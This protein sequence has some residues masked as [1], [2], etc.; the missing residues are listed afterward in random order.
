MLASVG[1]HLTNAEIA[2]RLFIS[3]RT[4]ESHVSSLLRKFGVADRRAL[5]GIAAA[6]G[7]AA[8]SDR[9]PGPAASRRSVGSL[10]NPL[11]PFVGRAVE[12]SALAA[13]LSQARLVTAVGPG[14]IGKTRLAVAVAGEVAERFADGVR[15]VDLVPVQPGDRGG[16]VADGLADEL[17]ELGLIDRCRPDSRHV[18]SPP[19]V[20]GDPRPRR[21]SAVRH[22]RHVRGD[23]GCAGIRG[24]HRSPLKGP[25]SGRVTP[26]ACPAAPRRPAARGVDAFGHASGF[27]SALFADTGR[28]QPLR[29]GGCPVPAITG[30]SAGAGQERDERTGP[31]TPCAHRREVIGGTTSA[32][33][34]RTLRPGT[35]KGCPKAAQCGVKVCPRG[36]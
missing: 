20:G 31:D 6:A 2:E 15:Y 14:G 35:K 22:V 26:D 11:T 1:G 3:V 17:L 7:G 18:D 24:G 30:E 12:R 27:V 8:V 25:V 13:A 23:H 9:I 34:G 21:V 19:A 16:H 29:G 5:A 33:N 36:V 32:R 4:V 28:L 10:P